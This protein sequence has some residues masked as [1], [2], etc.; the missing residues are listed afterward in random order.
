MLTNDQLTEG[1]NKAG[2]DTPEKLQ[3]FLEPSVA[4]AEVAGFD[5]LIASLV[6]KRTSVV[7]ELQQQIEDATASRELARAKLQVAK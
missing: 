4:N 2:I 6:A 1:Y 5:G 7:G 3:A